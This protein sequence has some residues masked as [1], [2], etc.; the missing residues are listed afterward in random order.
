VPR[1]AT[2][3][4]TRHWLARLGDRPLDR[5]RLCGALPELRLALLDAGRETDL[6]PLVA[7]G[8]VGLLP[9]TREQA[10]SA[11]RHR[12]GNVRPPHERGGPPVRRG[13]TPPRH[14]GWYRRS[15]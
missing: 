1:G 5:V 7:L 2:V 14:R 12:H 8:E 3:E 4:E 13:P 11:T 15:G 10:V 6:S 9:L